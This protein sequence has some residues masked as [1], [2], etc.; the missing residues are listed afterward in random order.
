MEIIRFFRSIPELNDIRKTDD[1][2][3][4]RK[5]AFRNTFLPVAAFKIIAR[6]GDAA[7]EQARATVVIGF[8]FAVIQ[9]AGAQR[10]LKYNTYLEKAF[11]GFLLARSFGFIYSP[12][13]WRYWQQ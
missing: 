12:G 3:Q 11:G 9:H 13:T 1:I 10:I 6:V 8:F 4:N 5:G 2:S 7:W